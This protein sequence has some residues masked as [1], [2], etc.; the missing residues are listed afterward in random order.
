MKIRINDQN[1]LKVTRDTM[2]YTLGLDFYFHIEDCTLAS[3]INPSFSFAI[4]I[5][6]IN[7]NL[8]LG[9]R[10]HIIFEKENN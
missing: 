8:L 4:I 7:Y 3:S 10:H 1:N 6:Y 2:T 5:N 9:H